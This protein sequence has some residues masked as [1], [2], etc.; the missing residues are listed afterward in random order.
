MDATHA[1]GIVRGIV[2][3]ER[4][5]YLLGK[6]M[7]QVQENS[8]SVMEIYAIRIQTKKTGFK[9]VSLEMLKINVKKK[10]QPK[11]IQPA[12]IS[13]KSN[14]KRWPIPKHLYCE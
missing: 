11:D 13:C 10:K 12:S 9:T 1:L 8:S 7:R 14:I 2:G 3:N 4:N 5:L 6:Q